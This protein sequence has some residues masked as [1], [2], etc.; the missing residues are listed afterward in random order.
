MN[1]KLKNPVFVTQPD[2]PPLGEFTELL[3]QI[4]D[5]KILTNNGPFHKQF[6]KALADYLGV[7]Y[8]SLFSNGTLALITALQTLRI[9]GEVIT[10]PYSFVATTHSLWWN[11]IKPVFADVEPTYF[12]LDPEKVE[13]AITPQTTAIM[14][15]HIYGYPCNIERFQQIADTYGLRLIYDAAHAFGLKVNGESILN[16]G[17]LSVLSFHA[18]KVFNTIEGGAI[19]CN[20]EKTKQRIDYLKNFGF[21]DETTVIA[22]G[23]NAKM[24]EVQAAYGILQL[25]YIDSLISKRR[26][27]VK[28]YRDQ[29]RNIDGIKFLDDI[30][31]VNHVYSYFPIFVEKE[32]YGRT[33]D[34]LYEEL[35]QHNIFGRRYFY[36]LISQFPTYRGL[37]SAKAE[38]LPIAS[39]VALEVI[40]LPLYPSLNKDAIQITTNTILNFKG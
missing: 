8:L 34:E 10:S 4:W 35:K 31:G 32:K 37:V 39:K 11:N 15:I 40:C 23:I 5:N 2:L 33:R 6:E 13:A 17:D 27:I 25:N 3:K 21:A 9:T 16:F 26:D 22:P 19:I 7:K 12:N 1:D 24:N 28:F 18:T 20:D 29:L 30:T 14:P 36:P 38:N